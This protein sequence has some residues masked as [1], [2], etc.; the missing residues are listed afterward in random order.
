M[1]VDEEHT[2]VVAE[3]GSKVVA[4]DLIPVVVL[5]EEGTEVADGATPLTRS[6][7][8]MLLP[9]ELVRVMGRMMITL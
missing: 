6:K 1:A 5:T 8:L 3:E 4:G 9:F 7:E 2:G